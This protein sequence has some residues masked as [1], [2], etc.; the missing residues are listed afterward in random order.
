MRNTESAIEAI[1][2]HS[3]KR[4]LSPATMHLQVVLIEVSRNIE[5]DTYKDMTPGRSSLEDPTRAGPLLKR[6]ENSKRGTNPQ[7]SRSSI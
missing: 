1:T 6:S 7:L 2:V 4:H 3:S 5:K